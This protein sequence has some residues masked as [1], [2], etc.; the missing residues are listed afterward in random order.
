[1]AYEAMQMYN[2]DASQKYYSLDRSYYFDGEYFVDRWGCCR[3]NQNH[4]QNHQKVVGKNF[5]HGV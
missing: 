4:K 5:F 2:V 1:M 3:Q